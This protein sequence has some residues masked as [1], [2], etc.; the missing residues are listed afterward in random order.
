MWAIGIGG[1]LTALGIGLLLWFLGGA[2]APTSGPGSGIG[3][4]QSNLVL[5]A[6][7]GLSLASGLALL[8]LGAGR[9]K[10]PSA[11]GTD[12]SHTPDRPGESRP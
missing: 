1:I 9:W 11:P 5:A 7:A 4:S 8:G 3:S 6:V 10:R 12:A 2:M